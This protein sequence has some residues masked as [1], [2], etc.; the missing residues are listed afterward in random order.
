MTRSSGGL[1]RLFAM[2]TPLHDEVDDGSGFP[3]VKRP[4][5]QPF[6]V[7]DVFTDFKRHD[8]GPEFHELDFNGT[9]T[10]PVHDH[11]L[12]GGWLNGRPMAMMAAAL[13]S[14]K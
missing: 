7:R 1:N 2:A 13:T 10:N 3:P 5:R 11:A 9:V 14:R 12:M 8:L 4:L 6:L